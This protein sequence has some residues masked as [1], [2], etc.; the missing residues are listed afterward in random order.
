MSTQGRGNTKVSVPNN[1]YN[2]HVFVKALELEF[3]HS[4]LQK[5]TCYSI[6]V[7]V[8]SMY[9]YVYGLNCSIKCLSGVDYVLL[10][11]L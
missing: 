2:V 6:I 7:F 4:C 5:N 3:M 1:W 8:C 9:M 11:G 10:F